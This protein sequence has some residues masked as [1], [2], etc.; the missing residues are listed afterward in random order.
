M[1]MRNYHRWFWGLLL[2]AVALRLGVLWEFLHANPFSEVLLYQDYVYWKEAGWKASGV[3]FPDDPFLVAPLYPYLLAA[4]RWL[5]GGLA[6]L[7][8]I[9]LVFN[10]L[11][12]WLVSTT[13]RSRFG[14]LAGLFALAIF[15]FS[16]ELAVDFTEVAPQTLQLLLVALLI[17][18]WA[19][20]PDRE[21]IGWGGITG[22]GL[23]LGLLALAWPPAL[24]LPPL[25]ALW[26][27]IGRGPALRRLVQAGAVVLLAA[28]VV[29]PA[30]WH[31]WRTDHTFIPVSAEIG[32]HMA[33][34]NNPQAVGVLSP[35]KGIEPGRKSPGIDMQRYYRAV[36][37]EQGSWSRIDALFRDMA[38]DYWRQQ[39]GEALLLMGRKAWW[40]LTSRAYDDLY[41]IPLMRELGL[42]RTL[43][44]APVELPWLMGLALLGLLAG[45]RLL[46]ELLTILLALFTVLLFHYSAR[47]RIPAA[48]GLVVLAAGA[49]GR[50][51]SLPLKEWGRWAIA[52]LPLPL[53][54]INYFTGLTS[55]EMLQR[56]TSY[57]VSQAWMESGDLRMADDDLPEAREH[58]EKAVKAQPAYLLPHLR[59]GLV[60]HRA[61]RME[62]A[63]N[64][65]EAGIP[66][67]KDN[68]MLY[69]MQYNLYR[70][71]GQY[72]KAL[73][74]LD[75]AIKAH[76]KSGELY[77]ARLWLL[78]TCVEDPNAQE[79]AI[80]AFRD[81]LREAGGASRPAIMGSL[82]LALA[83]AGRLEEARAMAN[84]AVK[85][86]SSDPRRYNLMAIRQLTFPV[87]SGKEIVCQAGQFKLPPGPG[88]KRFVLPMRQTD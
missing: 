84:E 23:L 48:P 47:Y 19:A 20:L 22:M 21:R 12:M 49:M 30:T 3:W 66:L 71:Q 76:P 14:D 44:L 33:E 54:V 80:Q 85:L 8:A 43:V 5:G 46:P 25:F 18:S 69:E 61:G 32:L 81:L 65:V 55:V 2:A 70:E 60:H 77:Q 57:Q 9:Q 38:L 26:L 11:A 6:T 64:A 63:L 36:K 86:A 4:I 10:I 17:R 37:G 51:S 87:R 74:V 34:G 27:L 67:V 40:F 45:R 78:A 1:T 24:L 53:A 42:Y 68:L 62:Q 29:S 13:A 35:V 72:D 73:E 39:P 58:Y 31:N 28:A 52:L 59:L 83:H 79:L 7:F 16:W 41:V 82:A 15:G 56:Q 50:W 88:D 75:A